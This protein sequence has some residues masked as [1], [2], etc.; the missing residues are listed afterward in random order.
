MLGLGTKR[1][2]SSQSWNEGN[3]KQHSIMLSTNL[4]ERKE[5]EKLFRCP[6]TSLRL[7]PDPN[8]DTIASVSAI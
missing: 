1:Y 4:L 2:E 6:T 8:Q 7:D 5:N 3:M